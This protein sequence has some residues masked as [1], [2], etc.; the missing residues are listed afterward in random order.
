MVGPTRYTDEQINFILDRTVR[1]I[2]RGETTNIHLEAAREYREAFGDPVFGLNQIRYVTE[3]Y[4]WDPDYGNRWGNLIHLTPQVPSARPPSEREKGIPADLTPGAKKLIRKGNKAK[5]ALCDHC[6]GTGV[7]T[8]LRPND[9]VNN[10]RLWQEPRTETSL[11]PGRQLPRFD[12]PPVI[13]DVR[14]SQ[15]RARTTGSSTQLLWDAFTT[16]SVSTRGGGN[17]SSIGQKWQWP[18]GHSNSNQQSSADSAQQNSSSELPR[19]V[20][21]PPFAYFKKRLGTLG[22]N[23]NDGRVVGMPSGPTTPVELP[24]LDA[25]SATQSP[26]V[27][28]SPVLSPPSVL[29]KRAPS[30]LATADVTSSER[31]ARDIAR[32]PED[33]QTG[34]GGVLAGMHPFDASSGVGPPTQH[35]Q[36]QEG[37]A[38]KRI[39]LANDLDWVPDDDNDAVDTGHSI[40]GSSGVFANHH[41]SSLWFHPLSRELGSKTKKEERVNVDPAEYSL[42]SGPTAP[43][44]PAERP[45]TSDNLASP[46]PVASA[47]PS[48]KEEEQEEKGPYHPY[49]SSFSA[50]QLSPT[51]MLK[52]EEDLEKPLA[53]HTLLNP[54]IK[55]DNGEDGKTFDDN[56]GAAMLMAEGD[57]DGNVGSGLAPGDVTSIGF[58]GDLGSFDLAEYGIPLPHSLR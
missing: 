19:M 54:A 41:D 17:C 46:S 5:F 40:I 11:R 22:A 39:K 16:P 21:P 44:S 52:T 38:V 18:F 55:D 36:Q 10:S 2:P 31:L 32:S 29:G 14:A 13:Q 42:A 35:Q 26:L 56:W 15:T 45:V 28:P 23:G 24:E 7:Q 51:V 49:P 33:W 9:P 4:G 3:R 1:E 27:R 34:S 58:S 48:L 53:L 47:L 6:G 37:S 8:F 30:E 43:I 25:T 50:S 12:W 20:A 57:L